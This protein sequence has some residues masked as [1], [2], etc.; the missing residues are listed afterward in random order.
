MEY[1]KQI[2]KYFS[3]YGSEVGGYHKKKK[4]RDEKVSFIDIQ[5]RKRRSWTGG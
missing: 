3:M 1:L 4:K 5:P 2:K